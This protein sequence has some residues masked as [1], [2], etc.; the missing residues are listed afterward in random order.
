MN[1]CFKNENNCFQYRVGAIII[2]NNKL[3]LA[4]NSNVD[5]YFTVG[6]RVQFGESSVEALKREI[7]EEIKINLDIEGL[8]FISENFYKYGPNGDPTHELGFYFHTK[9]CDE[10]DNID[11]EFY[12]KK[13]KNTL[14]WIPLSEIKNHR[15][16]PEMLVEQLLDTNKTWHIIT[17]WSDKENHPFG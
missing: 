17:C 3:L 9:D 7:F 2:H 13:Q 4:T 1:L 16:Y 15:I 8:A 10:L 12:E 6:G 5:F 11:T 14:H